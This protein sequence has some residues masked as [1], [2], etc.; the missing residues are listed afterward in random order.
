VSGRELI[1][2]DMHHG[3][4]LAEALRDAIAVLKALKLTAE[5]VFGDGLDLTGQPVAVAHAIGIVEGAAV[6]LMVTPVELLD[7]YGLLR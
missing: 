3:D 7:E 2:L 6:A 1:V 4:E 5:H